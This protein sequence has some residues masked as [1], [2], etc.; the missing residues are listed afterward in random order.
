[1]NQ[2]ELETNARNRRQMRE[3]AIGFGFESDWLSKWREFSKPITER[4]KAKS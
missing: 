4:S 3:N 1:M 2:Q